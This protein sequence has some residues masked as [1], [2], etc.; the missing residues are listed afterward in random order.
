ME[1]VKIGTKKKHPNEI[2]ESMKKD[3]LACSF[4]KFVFF[5]FEGKSEKFWKQR[6]KL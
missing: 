5:S 1:L 3:N 2:V 4:S 6:K